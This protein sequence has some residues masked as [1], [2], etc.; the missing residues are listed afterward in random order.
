MNKEEMYDVEVPIESARG[1]QIFRIKASDNLEA[2]RKVRD[3]GGEFIGEEVEI[4]GLDF[5]NAHAYVT[6][7][8]IEKE[9]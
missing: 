4:I 8:E 6:E 2:I 1:C 5:R 7:D 9:N 3:L